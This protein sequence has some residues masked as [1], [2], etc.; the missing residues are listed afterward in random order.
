MLKKNGILRIKRETVL[1]LSQ[2][3][4]GRAA[5]GQAPGVVVSGSHLADPPAVPT[6]IFTNVNCP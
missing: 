1:L 2:R 3:Q 6:T 4:L 5:G